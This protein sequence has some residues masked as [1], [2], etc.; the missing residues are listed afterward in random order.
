MQSVAPRAS[1]ALVGRCGARGVQWVLA[2][3]FWQRLRWPP[4]NAFPFD[5]L[6]K[7]EQDLVRPFAHELEVIDHKLF[8]P[9]IVDVGHIC[10]AFLAPFP[11]VDLLDLVV[12][13]GLA[14]TRSDARLA[15]FDPATARAK[16]NRKQEQT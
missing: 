3:F 15:S 13:Q 1:R 8:T 9:A 2:Q 14:P 4:R 5:A 6:F 7:F 12:L 16:R 11:L 10:D